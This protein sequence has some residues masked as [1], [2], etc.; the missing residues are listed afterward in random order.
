LNIISGFYKNDGGS[1]TLGDELMTGKLPDRIAAAGVMRTFQTPLIPEM[2]VRDVVATARFTS[3]PA[4]IISTMLRLPRYRAAIRRDRE[5]VDEVLAA[6]GLTDVAEL[7]AV[8]LPLGTRRVLELARALAGNPSLVLLDEVASGL[9][10][11]E[12]QSLSEVIR[13]IRAAG[14]TVLLVEHNFSLVR[15]LADRVVVLSQ[16]RLVAEGPPE[17]IATHP[18][19]LHH[20]LGESTTTKPIVDSIVDSVDTTDHFIVKGDISND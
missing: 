5:K 3:D 18:E 19:V 17:E 14:G 9:D 8:S 6:T 10:Q 12:I 4:G 11:E 16:G 15:D 1:I 2:S 7:E 20:Y 13:S